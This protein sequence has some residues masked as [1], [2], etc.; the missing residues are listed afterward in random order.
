[1]RGRLAVASLVLLAGLMLVLVVGELLGAG[2]FGQAVALAGGAEPTIRVGLVHSLT[3]PLEAYERPLHDAEV[4]ALA[5][6][7]ARGGLLGRRIEWVV[8]DG[9]SDPR[10]FAAEAR[11][12][13][14]SERVQAVIGGWTAECRRAM[15]PVVEERNSILIFPGDY[16]GL[17][18]SAHVVPAGGSANQQ[19]VPATRWILEAQGRKK[20]FVV[21][22]DEVWSRT[23]MAIVGDILKVSGVA[24]AG[25]AVVPPGGTDM[26]GVVEAI[27]KYEPDLILNALGGDSNPAF[28][29]ALRRAGV[30]ARAVPVLSF[31]LSEDDARRIDPADLDGHWIASDYFATIDAPGNL[32]FAERF[33]VRPNDDRPPTAPGVVAYE[34]ARI[35]AR[36]VEKGGDPAPARV[37]AQIGRTSLA[38]PEGV[39]TIDG[40]NLAAWR[41]I[42]VGRARPDGRFDLAWSISRPIRPAV[43]I[44]T[45]SNAEWEAFEAGL[46][47]GWRGGWSAPAAPGG[48]RPPG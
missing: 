18:Q 40:D 10:T 1:M 5:E 2:L 9:K 21:G 33:K 7:N 3:G 41:P 35:W 24:L 32:G 30:A 19:V 36:A 6:I 28:F 8:A 38:G 23:A 25:E 17:D 11:R 43:Y 45:R 47:A 44:P 48:P 4:F 39:I 31:R 22:N 29:A 46:R 42:H 26:A 15:Q 13:I 27:K 14:E 37:L 34:A 12:L 20:P 16:E